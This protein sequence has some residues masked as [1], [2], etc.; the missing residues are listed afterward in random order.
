MLKKSI[1]LTTLALFLFL[2]CIH[3]ASYGLYVSTTAQI[4]DFK[5]T[6]G[7]YTMKIDGSKITFVDVKTKKEFAATG[8]AE[9][10]A[11]KVPY[12]Q[13]LGPTADGVQKVTEIQIGGYNIKVTFQ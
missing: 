10:S 5:L 8:K 9:K 3:A 1:L 13:I 7:T 4:G 6:P 2:P 12:N 11:E